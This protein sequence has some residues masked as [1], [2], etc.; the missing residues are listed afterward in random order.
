MLTV[1]KRAN[2][3]SLISKILKMHQKSIKFHEKYVEHFIP[4]MN[5]ENFHKFRLTFLN[6]ISEVS[7]YIHSYLKCLGTF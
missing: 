2:H 4:H 7:F 6:L 3:K 1:E 5:F